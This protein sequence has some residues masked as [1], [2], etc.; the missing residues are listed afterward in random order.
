MEQ[1]IDDLLGRL[2][3]AERTALATAKAFRSARSRV[4]ALMRRRACALRRAAT[5]ERSLRRFSR[6]TPEWRSARMRLRQN[7]RVAQ[8]L[9]PTML[10]TLQEVTT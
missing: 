2:K 9:T 7:L 5:A 3:R 6:G 4:I 8:E 10:Q 1:A